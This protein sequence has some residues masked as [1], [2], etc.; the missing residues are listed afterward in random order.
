[1]D[2]FDTT[3][4]ENVRAALSEDIGHDDLTARLVADD[5]MADAQVVCRQAAVL[6][7]RP[8][9]DETFKQVDPGVDIEWNTTEGETVTADVTVCRIHGRA[10]SVL[11][12]ERTALNFLQTLS[13]TA[14][15]AHQYAEAIAGTGAR[16]LD[17]RKTVPG[18]RV[19][20]KYAVRCGGCH[21]HR[22]GLYDA[23]L[24]KENHIRS[25]GSITA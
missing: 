23:I 16:V 25:A 1:M 12:A 20:Q 17:T 19:A 5:A 2:D 6:C 24:I 13:G 9:F 4:H 21:N 3:V 18:L 8:W 14:T 15:A 7:G 11:T 22:M 10:R